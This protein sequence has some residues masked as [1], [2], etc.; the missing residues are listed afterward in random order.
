MIAAAVS[1]RSETAATKGCF[2][3]VTSHSDRL[4]AWRAPNDCMR[5]SRAAGLDPLQLFA[6]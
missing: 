4:A 5:L 1:C 2:A 6:S 3:L